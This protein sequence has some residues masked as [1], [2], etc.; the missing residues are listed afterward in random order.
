MAES[1]S[2]PPGNTGNKS[3]RKSRAASRSAVNSPQTVI[4][5]RNAIGWIDA[6]NNAEVTVKQIY[7]YTP[8]SED[9]EKRQKQKGELKDLEHAIQQKR[10]DWER[11]VG[12]SLRPNGNPYLF[13]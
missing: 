9:K 4:K 10:R 11:L 2:N 6:R 5:G 7:Q 12:A 13:M 3:P 1:R 8:L